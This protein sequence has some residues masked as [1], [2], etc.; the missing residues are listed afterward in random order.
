MPIFVYEVLENGKPT[1]EE[2]EIDQAT[3]DNPLSL[4][5]FT[6]QKIRRKL[7][8]PNVNVEYTSQKEKKIS[9]PNYISS[10]GFSKYEKDKISGNY[11][12]IAGSAGPDEI[13]KQ[14]KP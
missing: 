8:I 5:P 4:H 10:K 6:R 14:K 12:K 2:L 9:D 1:G 7:N 3:G 11:Y 13:I